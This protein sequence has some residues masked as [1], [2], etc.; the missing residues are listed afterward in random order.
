M[1]EIDVICMEVVV[2]RVKFVDPMSYELSE[3]IIKGHAK[4]IFQSKKDKETPRWGTYAKKIREVERKFYNKEIKKNVE[5]RIES[6]LKESGMTRQEFD[7]IKGITLEMKANG[8]SKVLATTPI[9]YCHCN[10]FRRSVNS[11]IY[12]TH[13]YCTLCIVGTSTTG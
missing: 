9:I 1:V 11:K 10:T 2:P 6:N 4:I 8:Q 7:E 13:T 12:F 5:K 3:E